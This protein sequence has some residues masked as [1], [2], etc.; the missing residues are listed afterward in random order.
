MSKVEFL[1]RY[2]ND[3]TFRAEARRK[4]I[5]VIQ[6]NVIFFNPDGS[7]KVIAGNYIRQFP[8]KKNKKN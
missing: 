2:R 5:R 8:N 3:Y 1:Q 4:G 7:L 6:D